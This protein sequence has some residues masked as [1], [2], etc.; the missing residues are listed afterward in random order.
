MGRIASI[1]AL[2]FAGCAG[3]TQPTGGCSL[4]VRFGSYAMGIDQRAAAAVHRII[5][6]DEGVVSIER[7]GAGREGEYGLCVHTRSAAATS[8][9]L[10]QIRS[11]LPSRPH[12]P[13][14][15]IADSRRWT[16]PQR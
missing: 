5:A 9:L 13:I 12:G 8:R 7:N 11:V 10:G 2:T 3:A 4:E 14:T 6:A 16:V 15:V 1:L